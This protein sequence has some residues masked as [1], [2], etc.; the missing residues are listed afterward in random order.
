MHLRKSGV[1]VGEVV[2]MC[3]ELLAA[4]H[5]IFATDLTE[6][7]K[8]KSSSRKHHRK[9]E[10]IKKLFVNQAKCAN[11]DLSFPPNMEVIDSGFHPVLIDHQEKLF[12]PPK[13]FCSLAFIEAVMSFCRSVDSDFDAGMGS[14]IE[15]FLRK[16][17]DKHNIQTHSGKYS[18][19]TGKNQVK[20]E[21]DLVVATADTIIFIESKKKALTRAAKSGKDTQILLDLAGSIVDSVVQSMRHEELLRQHGHLSL[22]SPDGTFRL[23]L[24]NRKVEHLSVTLLEF[25]S[26][27][28]RLFIQNFLKLCLTAKFGAF[29]QAHQPKFDSLNKK[30]RELARISNHLAPI[31]P[32]SL[33]FNVGFMSISQVLILLQNTKSVED[34][35]SALWNTRYLA[36]ATMDFYFEHRLMSRTQASNQD[37]STRPNSRKQVQH[38]IFKNTCCALS[39]PLGIYK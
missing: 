31:Y 3:S 15:L 10:R 21:C 12:L 9:I 17:F 26:L 34:F 13:S 30:L 23:E 28:S 29:D 1:N 39:V 32:N 5:D 33:F 20:G 19:G 36:S 16:E 2:Q 14:R 22:A 6:L 35:K 4:G 37:L 38:S 8:R 24:S 7:L 18:F 11:Q 27:Q 25:G